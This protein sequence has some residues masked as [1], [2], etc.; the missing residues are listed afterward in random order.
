MRLEATIRAATKD[1]CYRIAELFRIASGGV[2]DYVWSTLAPQYPGLTPLEVGARRYAREGTAFSYENCVVAERAGEVIGM[3]HA[4]PMEGEPQPEG[5]ENHV[6]PILQ[7]Y[8]KLEV[9]GSFYLS[10]MAVLPRDR[11]KGLG[12]RM[13][14]IASDLAR[15]KG[16]GKLS[17]LAF[18]QNAAAVRFYE[19]N[20]FE[21]VGRAPVVPHELIGHRGDVLLMA[22]EVRAGTPEPT[23]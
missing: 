23:P 19:R 21:V 15:Q 1:D 20:G 16:S 12:T 14:L 17:L 4:Y 18:E 3:L 6:D 11:G 22:A 2:A 8:A 13:L 10:A 5:A 9:R 7:P